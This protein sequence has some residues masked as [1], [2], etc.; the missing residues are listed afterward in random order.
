M[1]YLPGQILE[2]LLFT[3]PLWRFRRVLAPITLV[4]IS[5]SSAVI[6]MT[7]INLLTGGM[8]LLALFRLI[9]ILRISHGRMHEAY[10]RRVT[11]RSSLWLIIYFIILAVS[12]L[13]FE[14]FV[15]LGNLPTIY[16]WTCLA[17]S[18]FIFI[19]TMR[20]IRKTR[21]LSVLEHYSD[22]ELP[23]VT[24]AIPARNETRDLEEC[25]KSILANNYPKLE[26]L[27]LD[28]CSQDR[29]PEIIRKFAQDGV[30][31]IPG[32]EPDD[33]WLAKN[34]AYEHLYKAANG[35]LVLFC[36][37]DVR[38]G[39]DAVR[40][41]VTSM[42]NRKKDMLSILPRRLS[43]SSSAALIQPMRYWWELVLPRRFFN[44]PPVL[45]TCWLIKR[46]TLK[47]LGGFAAVSHAII[48]EGYFAREIIKHDG[49]S[50]IRAD[51]LLDVQTRKDLFQQ[52]EMALRMRYPQLRRKLELVLTVV[53]VH[54]LFLIGPFLYGLSGFWLG[55]DGSK[56]ITWAAFGTLLLT[57][58]T[59]VQITSPANILIAVIN[60]P[61]VL[62]TE[63]VLGL[64]S[65]WKYEFAEVEW[66]DRN[67]CIPVM[68][69]IPHLPNLPKR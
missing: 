20:N 7:D 52:R 56:L 29:T 27:V 36:G 66:K 53:L 67:I 41:M 43:G 22:K 45:S 44:R 46:N 55:F 54:A 5:F 15:G 19:E 49:Y 14:S 6:F 59:I 33:R 60:L 8:L 57:H 2:L 62:I 50:F 40:A 13:L 64:A 39:A 58:L 4:T 68:H 42:I 18:V 9:N 65:M 23:T 21:H 35:E 32:K 38:F 51:D 1:L 30:R 12:Y 26:I 16:A 34:Q 61:V 24:I 17:L 11:F 69:V 3:P 63:I 28:D 31:F 37:V 25:I 48:P 10:L 47:K